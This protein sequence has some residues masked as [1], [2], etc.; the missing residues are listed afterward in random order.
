MIKV[1]FR[2]PERDEERERERAREQQRIGVGRG[3][4][5][6]PPTLS[7]KHADRQLDRR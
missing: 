6:P 3:E 1:P 2:N 5:G 4:R 7:D